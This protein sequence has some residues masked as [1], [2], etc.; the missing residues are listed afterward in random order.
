MVQ[1]VE[2]EVDDRGRIGLPPALRDRLGLTPG[3]TLVVE[4]ESAGGTYLRVRE[5]PARVVIKQGVFVIQAEPAGEFGDPV[6]EL[7]E[8]RIASVAGQ[9]DR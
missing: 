8:E 1:R 9:A 3:M 5:E 2:V 4:Q 6:R 7:R